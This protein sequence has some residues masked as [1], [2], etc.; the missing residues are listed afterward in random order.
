VAVDFYRAFEDRHRGSRAI[1]KSRL[2]VYLPLVV[3]LALAHPGTPVL[4][5]G[6]GRGEWLELLHD[7][8]IPAQGVD[9]DAGMLAACGELGLN[10]CNADALAHLGAQVDRSLLVVSGFHLAEHLPFAS[11]QTLFDQAHRVLVPGGL[12]ILETP[13]PENLVV[14]TASFYLDPTHHRPLPWPLLTFM[15]E[16]QGFGRIK[17]MRLQEE[18]RLANQDSL[19]G[20]FDVLAGASPDYAIVAQKPG[21]TDQPI[22]F[23]QAFTDE[24]GLSLYTLANRYDQCMHEALRETTHRLERAI[25][26]SQHTANQALSL[27]QNS[28]ERAEQLASTLSAVYASHS[29]RLTQPL[30]WLVRFFQTRF[31]QS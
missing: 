24:T 6:C 25:E 16:H 1:I 12:L 22:D 15:A 8:N 28:A 31:K 19:L 26:S 17:L 11:L 9:L 10:V 27:A 2:G 30:R 13:N 23:E 5:L 21:V 20:L 18:E 29:W 7:N 14:G 4:D 3:P